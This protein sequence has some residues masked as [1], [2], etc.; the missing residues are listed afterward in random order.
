VRYLV[1]SPH[2]ERTWAIHGVEAEVVVLVTTILTSKIDFL[3]LPFSPEVAGTWRCHCE[4]AALTSVTA[5][6]NQRHG[7]GIGYLLDCIRNAFGTIDEG[8]GGTFGGMQC[9]AARFASDGAC[10]ASERSRP[11]RAARTLTEGMSF[12]QVLESGEYI[13]SVPWYDGGPSSTLHSCR[14]AE[15][16]ESI[17]GE[18]QTRSIGA[19]GFRSDCR[20]R[21]GGRRENADVPAAQSSSMAAAQPRFQ[22]NTV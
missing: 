21:P 18:A 2:G 5:K 4:H 17:V 12:E 14:L 1:C 15:H 22:V 10:T 6:L 9:D 20:T 7:N 11:C 8:A 16:F 13:C 3:D 19:C